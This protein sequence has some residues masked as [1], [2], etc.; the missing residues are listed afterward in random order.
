MREATRQNL[1]VTIVGV[2]DIRDASLRVFKH[3]YSVPYLKIMFSH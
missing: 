3:M 1:R 2:V